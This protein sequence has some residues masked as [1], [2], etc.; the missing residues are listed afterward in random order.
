MGQK[1]L[2]VLLVVVAVVFVVTLALGASHGPRSPDD[3]DPDGI[4]FL[5]GLQGNRFLR[6][7]RQG[8]DDVPDDST[9]SR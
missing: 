8:D 5:D 6:H 7:R 9:R 1:L 4:G 3:S 2:I